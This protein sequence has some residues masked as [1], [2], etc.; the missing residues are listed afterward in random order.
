MSRWAEL[1]FMVIG[2]M[3]YMAGTASAAPAVA[4][5][6]FG[7]HQNTAA[8]YLVVDGRN[9][10]DDYIMARL[11]EKKKFE[12][13]DRLVIEEE[14][15]KENLNITGVIDADTAKR[16]GELLGV[17][18]IIYGNIIDVCED[19]MGGSYQGIGLDTHTIISHINLRM[20]DTRTGEILAVVKGEGR[21]SG[22][23]VKA[24]IAR[25]DTVKIGNISASMDSVHNAVKKAAY[26]AVDKLLE[27]KLPMM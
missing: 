19:S 20:M 13:T 16:L 3:V 26:D 21:S 17:P 25:I 6:D 23:Y 18:Y 1:I 2:I 11:L 5:M 9:A 14:I 12:L 7:I 24:K 8:E 10:A 22:S 27:K 4:V 15:N